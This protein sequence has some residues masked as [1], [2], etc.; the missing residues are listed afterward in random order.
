[1]LRWP[2]SYCRAIHTHPMQAS[3]TF[4]GRC[5]PIHFRQLPALYAGD[6]GDLRALQVV[7]TAFNA[8]W[9]NNNK[10]VR[11]A[12]ILR[13]RAGSRCPFSPE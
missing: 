6:D 13:L 3:S 5:W 1:M 12:P 9:E 4:G 10:G 2:N 7:N 8:A 11:P